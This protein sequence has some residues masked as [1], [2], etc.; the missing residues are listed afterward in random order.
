MPD[1]L[2]LECGR[3]TPA[4]EYAYCVR[5]E[6]SKAFGPPAP[7]TYGS[8]TWASAVSTATW[9]A[10]LGCDDPAGCRHRLAAVRPRD[11]L[12]L[13]SG[14]RRV[15]ALV[16][17]DLLLEVRLL[18]G[19]SSRPLPAPRRSPARRP[20]SPLAL[21][22]TTAI[23]VTRSLV[24][25][26]IASSVPSWCTNLGGPAGQHHVQP[27]EAVAGVGRA[28]QLADL[29]VEGVEP[30]LRL[31]GGLLGC[32]D[33][34]LLRLERDLGLVELLGDDLQLMVGLGDDCMAWAAR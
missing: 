19:R 32:R 7:Q 12:L 30:R 14:Q 22:E 4:A 9:A 11:L 23:S 33:S 8:P 27:R 28:R 3:L 26:A 15:L 10:W 25:P 16:V 2:L 20:P 6:Q 13:G 5:P 34:G 1:W 18:R 31:G 29:P 24:C 21:S 17:L